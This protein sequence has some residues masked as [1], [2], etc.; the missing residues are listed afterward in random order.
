[1]PVEQVLDVTQRARIGGVSE[2]G[3]DET[4]RRLGEPTLTL[5]G[6]AKVFVG[7]VPLRRY[8][9]GASTQALGLNMPA[10]LIQAEANFVMEKIP[11]ALV[12]R[13]E[14]QRVRIKTKRGGVVLR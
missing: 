7:V 10:E 11:S 4:V 6:H 12:Y 3:G 5:Q 13:L 8:C 1:M 14:Q 2:H 9:N